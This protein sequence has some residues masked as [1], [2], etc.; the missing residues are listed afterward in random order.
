M[1]KGLIFDFDG[2]IAESIHIKSEAFKNLYITYGDDIAERVLEHHENNGGMSRFEKI[3]Y[4]H[5]VFLYEKIS[6]QKI[7][8]LSNKFS[9]YVVQKVIESSYI[10][11]VLDYIKKSYN[12]YKLFI[13]TG[14]PTEEIKEILI[15]KK[16][17]N[18]F[19][20]IFGSPSKKIE[21]INQIIL[22]YSLKSNE[23]IFYGDSFT[24]YD[25]ARDQKI[26][27]VL[28]KNKYN[29]N[30]LDKHNGEAINDFIGLK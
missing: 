17:Y 18:Y 23:L 24:D 29:R 2:V 21:H 4:Y 9:S 7:I 12:K 8:D 15:G 6:E 22:N 10:P 5:E 25:A 14:T 28:I 20:D 26:T 16:I 3:K 1:I 11:G 13:S 30:I 27:F 19:T